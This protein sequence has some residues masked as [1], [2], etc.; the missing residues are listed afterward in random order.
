MEQFLQLFLAL[1]WFLE[2][3][4]VLEKDSAEPTGLHQRIEIVS[5]GFHVA[6][7]EL[8]F[9]VREAAKDFRS[10]L[11]IGIAF[12]TTNPAPRV[13]WRRDAI[14]GRIDLDGV[15]K[16]GQIGECVEARS[17]GR[18]DGSLPV[19][20]APASGTDADCRLTQG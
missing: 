17:V 20:V 13:C 15:E 5:K 3:P 11:E 14:E 6:G 12:H 9:L 7:D 18:I 1:G 10:E 16:R 4:R 19:A 2:T 8:R